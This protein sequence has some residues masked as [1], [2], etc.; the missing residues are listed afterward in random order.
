MKIIHFILGKA[1]PNRLNGVN[2]VVD[3]LA[4]NQTIL[5]HKVEVWGV[6]SNLTRNFPERLYKTI[7]F[8]KRP[9]WMGLDSKLK[10][11]L[12]KE[13]RQSVFHLHGGFVLENYRFAQLLKKHGFKYVYT[14]HGSFNHFALQKNRFQKKVYFDLLERKLLE[15]ASRIH[16]I[17]KSELENTAKIFSS[18]KLFL[19][20]NGQSLDFD[21]SREGTVKDTMIFS[22]CG[23]I[24]EQVKGLD[25]LIASF[26]QIISLGHKNCQ[27]WL[28]GDGPD[29][30]KLEERVIALG[31]QKNVKFWGA[32]YGTEKMILM[33][34]SHVFFHPSR[35][36]GLPSAVLE[37]GSLRLPVVVS[38]ETN[39]EEAVRD[40]QAG[41][42][43]KE[44]T[45]GALT[46]T[47]R[48]ILADPKYK[49]RGDNA[50]V[51][52]KQLFDWQRIAKRMIKEYET[53]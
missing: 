3:A 50:K 32:K 42:V 25:H 19:L 41:W 27:L 48:T 8:K 39:M 30:E 49:D 24:K 26:N 1:N 9:I 31:I 12:F 16:L 44:N 17:G 34:R 47:M 10:T 18:E 46:E 5:G 38:K 2:K 15:G 14:P 21:I 20:P 35:Y 51:M 36:E 29:K 33:S 37:A 43:L 23:R 6:T 45:V 4:H 52:V 11:Y 22:F 28:I 13:A 53:A 40:Y 7:L